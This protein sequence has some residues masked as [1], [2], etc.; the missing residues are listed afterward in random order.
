[1]PNL[2]L[3]TQIFYLNRIFD[4]LSDGFMISQISFNPDWLNNSPFGEFNNELKIDL[5]T[6]ELDVILDKLF[7]QLYE[8]NKRF[9]SASKIFSQDWNNEFIL[10]S[11]DETKNNILKH[12]MD[13]K[14]T[15]K[16]YYD[17]IEDDVQIIEFNYESKQMKDIIFFGKEFH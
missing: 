6:K 15:F 17:I 2:E 4:I 16:T 1:M 8:H 9:T 14:I 13:K 10:K 5:E 3:K 7:T 12:I 11:I